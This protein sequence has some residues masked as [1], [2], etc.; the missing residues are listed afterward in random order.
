MA[1]AVY[2]TQIRTHLF[3]HE[4]GYIIR[5][6]SDEDAGKLIKA[7]Y[8]FLYGEEPEIE[9]PTLNGLLQNYESFLEKGA[10]FYLKKHTGEPDN[11][12]QE[13]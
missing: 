4:W 13:E 3:H 8:A 10:K 11:G 2:C 12:K 5:A 1:K 9:D 6:L 7:L